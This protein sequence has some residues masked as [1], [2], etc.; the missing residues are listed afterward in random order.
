MDLE[1]LQLL[2]RMFKKY[3]ARRNGSQVIDA[4]A[5]GVSLPAGN[6]EAAP[7]LDFR[8]PG[9]GAPGVQGRPTP[10]TLPAPGRPPAPEANGA[11]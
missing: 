8:P 4:P 10:L 11:H 2:D 7:A 5:V 3:A 9:S 1:D 6:G